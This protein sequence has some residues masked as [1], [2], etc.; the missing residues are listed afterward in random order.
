MHV[1]KSKIAENLGDVYKDINQI[2]ISEKDSFESLIQKFFSVMTK[3]N[4]CQG[5]WTEGGG[6]LMNNA[7]WNMCW[8]VFKSLIESKFLW[9]EF[10]MNPPEHLLAYDKKPKQVTKKITKKAT[11]KK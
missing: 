4:I 7:E 11:K 2:E 9:F 5:E 6:R 3:W 10:M 1:T 8:I